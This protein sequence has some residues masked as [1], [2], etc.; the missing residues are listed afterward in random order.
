MGDDSVCRRVT[1]VVCVLGARRG[2][3]C[4]CLETFPALRVEGLLAARSCL[5]LVCSS[6]SSASVVEKCLLVLLDG[7]SPQG[8]GGKSPAVDQAFSTGERARFRSFDGSPP[9]SVASWPAGTVPK[10]TQ[11]NTPPRWTDFESLYLL[12]R[13]AGVGKIDLVES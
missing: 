13:T 6:T 4:D 12:K 1:T 2:R 9:P 3:C 7:T 5:A 8:L 10:T 11:E